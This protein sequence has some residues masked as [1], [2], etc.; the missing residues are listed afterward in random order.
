VTIL[1]PARNEEELLPRCLKSV[2][3]A[4]ARLPVSSTSDIVIAVD[5]S[6]DLTLEIAERMVLN[7][8]AVITTQAGAVGYA[9]SLAAKTALQRHSGPLQYC[10]LAN[11]DADCC[12]P[13]TWLLDQ[14]ALAE[15]GAEA[16]AGIVDVDSFE[17]HDV[18]VNLCFRRSYLIR[19][20]GSH[21]HVHG[22]NLGIRADAYLR[23][24]GWGTLESAEDHDLWHRLLETGC[25]VCST[26]Y[27]KVLT[28][29]RRVGRAPQGFAAAL[30]A[31]DEVQRC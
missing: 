25:S 3:A 31:H 19:S 26:D 29:G 4:C 13:D 8:G 20:D 17:E 27:V 14:L 23:A 5:S 12:V 6:T 18:G 1:I 21:P 9:R 10:W 11:T 2:L 28:S 24:G 7:R 30:C 22:A 16:I 15:Q